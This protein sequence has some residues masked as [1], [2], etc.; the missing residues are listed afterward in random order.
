MKKLL[1]LLL[2]FAIPFLLIGCK[3][4]TPDDTT[5]NEETPTPI[6]ETVYYSI[7]FEVN[8]GTL[9]STLTVLEGTKATMPADPTKEGFIFAG[10]Y[11][12]ADFT[13]EQFNFDSTIDSDITLYAK[14]TEVVV[15]LTETEKLL[16]DVEAFSSFGEDPVTTS[17]LSLPSRGEY[18]TIFTWTTSNATVI[19]RSGVVIP[20]PIGGLEKTATL[21]LSARNGT[22]R[23]TFAYTI[24]VPPKQESIITSSSLLPFEPLT[25]EYAITEGDLMTYFVDHGLVPYVNIESFINMLDGFIYADEIEYVFD[26]LTEILVMSYSVTYTNDEEDPDDDETYHYQA[27]LDFTLN[28]ITIADRSF[29]SAYIYSTGTDYSSGLTY[30]DDYYV[31]PGDTI[32]YDLNAYRFDMIY[33]EGEYIMPFHIANLLFAGG[34]YFNVYYNGDGYKGVYAF[35]DDQTLFRT[36]SLNSTQIPFDVRLANFDFFAF[37]LDYFYGLKWE[38]NVN[39]YYDEL[40]KVTNDLLSNSRD[41][42]ARGYSNFVLKVLDDLHTSFIYSSVYGTPSGDTPSISLGDLGTHVKAW[43]DVYFAISD[44]IT[45]RWGTAD[46]I[47][48]FRIIEDTNTAIIYLARFTTKTI[49]DPDTVID[50]NDYMRDAIAGI[51]AINPNIEN[52]VVDISSNTGGNL[53]ALYRVLGYITDNP[54]EANYQDPLTNK[55]TT[56]WIDVDTRATQVNWFFMI[57]KRTFSAANL[58]AAIGKYQGLATIIGTTSGGGACSILPIYT[59]DGSIYQI[60]SLNMISYRVGSDEDGWEYISV[61]SG[62]VPDYFL[63]IT[64]IFNDASIASLIEAINNNTATPYQP[65]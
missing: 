11:V 33:H 8:G 50:S 60:S 1:L 14:W 34:S 37:T 38:K 22:V 4:T 61:E 62:V 28:T 18:G 55:K 15:E 26:A 19:T 43:Y 21:S 51:L 7:T 25:E 58:M 41:S 31:E 3:P 53:G 13:G 63:S 17:G 49:E 2:L 47:P 36:S 12:N 57:S 39:T 30:L 32:I 54:I 20:D 46:Q 5:P 59:P 35:G 45:A 44:G 40:Y 64:D 24:V 48:R 29:F 27:T 16:L 42:A 6:V 10:W 65:N 23:E 52:I 9:I 56:Y